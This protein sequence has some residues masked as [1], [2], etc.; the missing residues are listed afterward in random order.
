MKALIV[1]TPATGHLN[2]LLLIGRSLMEEGHD[3]VFLT[4]SAL[5]QRVE[6]IGARLSAFPPDADL[7]LRDQDAVVPELKNITP[8]PG[9]AACCFGAHL[10]RHHSRAVCQYAA[11]LVRFP[12]RYHRWR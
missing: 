1:S 8:G 11:G 9:M 3:V 2:P 10:C 6:G 5:R 12:G 4:G 7:D